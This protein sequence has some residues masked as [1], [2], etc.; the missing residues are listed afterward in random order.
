MNGAAPG[1]EL[2]IV[3]P[4][5]PDHVRSPSD[6]LR[7][8]V[9]AVLLV[10]LSAVERLFGDAWISFAADVSTGGAAVASWFV[11]LVLT[12]ARAL[13]VVFLLGGF[14]VTVLRGRWRFLTVVA[15]AAVAAAILE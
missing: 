7:L 12:V 15:I 14:V 13:A 1:V 3:E 2:V 10:A 6:V 11:T 8:V 4:P 9:S 5:Q